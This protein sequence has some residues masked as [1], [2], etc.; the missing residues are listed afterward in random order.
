M[1]DYKRCPYFLWMLRLSGRGPG[2]DIRIE[3]IREELKELD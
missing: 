2:C 3:V 1:V